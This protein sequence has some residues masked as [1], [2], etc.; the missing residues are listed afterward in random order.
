[1]AKKDPD[2]KENTDRKRERDQASDQIILSEPEKDQTANAE[3]DVKNAHA[4]GLGSM[5]RN[6]E[7]DDN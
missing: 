3:T 6:D 7:K 5:G 1:M 2:I 4:S